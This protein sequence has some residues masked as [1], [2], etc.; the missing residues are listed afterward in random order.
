MNRT[1]PRP[2]A[3]DDVG[4]LENENKFLR[5][6]I[7]GK[8]KT[9]EALLERDRETNHLITGLQKIPAPLPGRPE[10]LPPHSSQSGLGRPK[11]CWQLGKTAIRADM[12]KPAILTHRVTSRAPIDALHCRCSF[13][14]RLEP[15]AD[16]RLNGTA[17]RRSQNL[18]VIASLSA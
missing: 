3:T 8:D 7:V 17:F 14:W 10:E 15:H 2:V 4:L 18:A 16:V 9:I 12:A 11:P 5:G 6:Q 1:R 13:R